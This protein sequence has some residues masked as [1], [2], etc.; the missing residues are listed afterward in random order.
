MSPALLGSAL[1]L[2][3]AYICRSAIDEAST[4]ASGEEVAM[5]NHS[6]HKIWV[7]I[8]MVMAGVTEAVGGITVGTVMVGAAVTG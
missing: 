8:Q 6:K 1:L 3:I 4:E 7:R 2:L 5:I